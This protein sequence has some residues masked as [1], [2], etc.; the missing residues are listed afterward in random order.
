MFIKGEFLF[1]IF[2][3]VLLP[4]TGVSVEARKKNVLL[5]LGKYLYY[6]MF[7]KFARDCLS[8]PIILKID[9]LEKFFNKTGNN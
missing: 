6:K 7:M 3:F 4:R 9:S 2:V 5:L 1:L 8:I